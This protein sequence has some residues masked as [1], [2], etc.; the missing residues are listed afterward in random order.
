MSQKAKTL[1]FQLTIFQH[2]HTDVN[3]MR[4]NALETNLRH[5]VKGYEPS[6]YGEKVISTHIN[7]LEIVFSNHTS[8]EGPV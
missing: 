7:F 8:V 1:T 6:I 3:N 5:R 4:P 2:F